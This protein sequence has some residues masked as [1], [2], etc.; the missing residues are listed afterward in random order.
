MTKKEFVEL[1]SKVP[2][3]ADILE[4]LYTTEGVIL[5]REYQ[6]IPIEDIIEV[7]EVIADIFD[8][9]GSGLEFEE[10]EEPGYDPRYTNPY[11]YKEHIEGEDYHPLDSHCFNMPLE[12]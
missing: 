3:T 7:A 4:V 1:I 12:N 2:D 9:R 11:S 10:L 8:N 5:E 6:S